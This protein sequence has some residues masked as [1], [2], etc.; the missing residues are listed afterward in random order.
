MRCQGSI[1]PWGTDS[2]AIRCS[3][4]QPHNTV[5]VWSDVC[6]QCSLLCVY[7]TFRQQM[8]A[9]TKAEMEE[10][11]SAPVF[12][13]NLRDIVSKENGFAHFEARLEPIGDPTLKV[14]WLKDGRPMEASEYCVR[15]QHLCRC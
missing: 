2:L 10:A 6:V 1:V 4:L 15:L 5:F 11:I 12:K 14:E 7:F 13:T 8:L 9:K 3:V